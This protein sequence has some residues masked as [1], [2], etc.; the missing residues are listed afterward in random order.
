MTDGCEVVV[1][2]AK[3]RGSEKGREREGG[4]QALH[5]GARLGWKLG[6]PGAGEGERKPEDEEAGTFLGNLATLPVIA[7]LCGHSFLPLQHLVTRI[8][9]LELMSCG[10]EPERMPERP[11]RSS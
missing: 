5:F 3:V 2:S 4:E 1:V 10:R 6:A 7:Q 8:D 11:L 9:H